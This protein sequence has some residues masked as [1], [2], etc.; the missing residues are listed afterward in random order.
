M[1]YPSHKRLRSSKTKRVC[2][3]AIYVIDIFANKE[4]LDTLRKDYVKTLFFMVVGLD[5]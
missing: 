3:R 4:E 5:L 2:G 1:D